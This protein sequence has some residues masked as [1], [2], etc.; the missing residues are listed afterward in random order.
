MLRAGAGMSCRH[1]RTRLRLSCDSVFLLPLIFC[2]LLFSGVVASAEEWRILALRVDFP[3][4]SPDEATTTGVG[5]FDL[6]F[7]TD[8][9]EDYVPPYDL[10]PHDRAYFERHLA[11]LA[12]YYQVVSDGRVA[13]ESEVFPRVER[14]AYTLP[15]AMLHYSNGRTTE[16]IGAKWI[17]LLRD[18]IDMALADPDG[19]QL[20]DFNSFLVFHAG[21]GHE[22][23]ELNDIRS[24]FL[25]KSD[26]T[27]FNGG[28]LTFA[29]I[30][31]DEAWILPESPS[32]NGRA[33]LNGLMA[34]FFGNQ[35]GLPGLSN[36]ADGLPAVGGWSLMDVG[37]NALGFVLT[38]SLEPVIGFTAPHPMAW[39]K[40]RL[41]W[42]EPL[43]VRRDTVV[44]LLATDRN[45]DLPKALR[46]P[47][48]ADEYFL[49]ENRQQR[50]RRGAPD[51]Q[52]VRGVDP[53][54]VLWLDETQI[55]LERGVWVGVEDYDAFI[56]GSG[57]LIWHVD[58]GVI[59][60]HAVDG[61]IN[62]RPER[63]GIAL[64]EADGYR[65]IG[66]PV[67]ER[68]RQ[69]E[70]SP[71]DPFFVGGQILFGAGTRPDSRSN[72]GWETGIEI[73]VL[74]ALGDTM[75]VAIRF[76][77]SRPG[78]PQDLIG[79]GRLQAADLDGNG[80][81]ELL[82]EAAAGI[83]YADEA[84]IAPWSI[85][86]GR[87]VAVGD[88]DGD[89]RQEIFSISGAEVSAW[90]IGEDQVLWSAEVAG[91][92]RDGLFSRGLGSLSDFAGAALLLVGPEQLDI[93]DAISGV[94]EERL[95]QAGFL[96]L[97]GATGAVQDV[98]V[99]ASA[100]SDL[101]DE[102]LSPAVGDLDGDGR[103][104]WVLADRGGRVQL[105]N[106]VFVLGDSL[107]V[108]PVL[109]D[110]D[111]DGALEVVL[112]ARGGRVHVLR[113]DGL[114]QA[115]FP[116]A[117]PRFAAVGDLSFEPVLFD[118]DADGKQEIFLAGHSGIFAIDDTGHLLPGFPL[119][120]ADEPTSAPVVLDLDGD[121]W[122]ELA[123]LDGEALYVWDP[124]RVVASYTGSAA[125]WPQAR[126][127]AAGTRTVTAAVENTAPPVKALLPTAKAYCYPNPVGTGEAAHLRFALSEPAFVELDVFDAL[128]ARVGGEHLDSFAVGEHEITWSVDDYQSGLYICRLQARVSGGRQAE[129][130][131]KMAVSQ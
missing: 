17:E 34:K 83:A 32:L 130:L 113:F 71:D 54:E 103:V 79:D 48:D 26:F 60:Q 104:E 114:Q 29:G 117:L 85:A 22:T 95:S 46:V 125:H 63:Q 41:G 87:L 90:A 84:G 93:V 76:G 118:I 15:E 126:A 37:A 72:R 16:E 98:L 53:D 123:A 73:E 2:L 61:A 129:V 109:G 25:E 28:P 127:N 62:N 92:L 115:D 69:I 56:P 9:G 102:L 19:P 110:L 89:G 80:A 58:D 86:A 107:A 121:G 50:G 96:G 20:A 88:A 78:W 100:A 6:R 105:G 42:I 99:A 124:Q 116:F 38:D 49:L 51:G 131:V 55:E 13:I 36:F 101:Q 44:S 106:R 59:E 8:A 18:A 21:V 52:V 11:A 65:D 31:I 43:V 64:E 112:L 23:G 7:A 10:P 94:L 24:V 5:A 91:E 1:P 81:A 97:V 108:P 82:F 74:S 68:L 122:L 111:G 75:Q 77:R 4:E 57:V 119:L 27:R 12:R 33:G 3:L 120:T 70:G 128:G 14:Q 40:A 39:S 35:L 45:G 47:I 66:N 67:F 30:E